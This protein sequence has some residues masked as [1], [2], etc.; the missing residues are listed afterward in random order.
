MFNVLCS[1]PQNAIV[2]AER[3]VFWSGLENGFEKTGFFKP[4]KPQKSKI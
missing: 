3:T 2:L 1:D 4:K